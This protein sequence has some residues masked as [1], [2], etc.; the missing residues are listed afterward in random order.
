M[1][2]NLTIHLLLLPADPQQT[3]DGFKVEIWK[4]QGKTDKPISTAISDAKGQV[5]FSFKDKK[6]I[7]LLED[8]E[9]SFYFKVYVGDELLIDTSGKKQLVLWDI[10]KERELKVYLPE[11]YGVEEEDR[12]ENRR[13]VSFPL[14][15]LNKGER[16]A[17]LHRALRFLKLAV[18]KQERT[19]QRF[20]R[21]TRKTILKFQQ[22]NRLEATGIVDEDT[23]KKL[24]E[25]LEAKGYFKRTV[26]PFQARF[27]KLESNTL[28]Q[29]DDEETKMHVRSKLNAHLSST[30]IAQ[31]KAPSNKLKKAIRDI[32]LDIESI[33]EKELMEVI[34]EDVLPALFDIDD[35]V[36]ELDKFDDD[37]FKEITGTVK[38]LLHL[39]RPFRGQ[40][41]VC[42]RSP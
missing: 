40:S 4:Y 3:L 32:D 39:D 30:L 24:N 17:T 33:Q 22:E 7:A 15:L 36:E 23:S 25:L 11:T 18:L 38:G 9:H 34:R 28:N 29:L 35:L 20:G 19:T 42:Q 14:R 31:F 12:E 26:P 21:S 8:K 41:I 2:T 13:T 37:I 27:L 16:V 1:P 5:V 10:G 6:V